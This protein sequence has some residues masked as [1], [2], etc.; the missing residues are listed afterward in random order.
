MQFFG[1]SGRI[2][3]SR[4]ASTLGIVVLFSDAD[5]IHDLL[6]PPK[7]YCMSEP[8]PGVQHDAEEGLPSPGETRTR[9]IFNIIFTAIRRLTTSL[10]RRCSVPS[11]LA[12]SEQKAARGEVPHGGRVEDSPARDRLGHG[13][14]L[15][16]HAARLSQMLRRFNVDRRHRAEIRT[17]TDRSG[18]GRHRAGGGTRSAQ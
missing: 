11:C 12:A 15:R 1:A 4:T 13:K 5:P 3:D 9:V 14:S 7:K 18:S 6:R 16:V 10:G 17:R 2:D 8:C